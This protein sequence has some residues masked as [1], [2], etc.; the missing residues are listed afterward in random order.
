MMSMSFPVRGDYMTGLF[1]ER[2]EA[3]GEW[4]R[5]QGIEACTRLISGRNAHEIEKVLLP[6][7]GIGPK[8]LSTFFLLR[9]I[10][11]G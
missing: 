6:I 1:G 3:L 5:Q 2:L 10:S 4:I 11:R 8:V 7:K 9:E